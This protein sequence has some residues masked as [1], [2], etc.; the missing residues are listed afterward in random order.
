MSASATI[1]ER[2]SPQPK[3]WALRGCSWLQPTHRA[4]GPWEHLWRKQNVMQ[5]MLLC[6]CKPYVSTDVASRALWFLQ[7]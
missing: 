4:L 7:G 2:D 6:C 5:R 1:K 3:D